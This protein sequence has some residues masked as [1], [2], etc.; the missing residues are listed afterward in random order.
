MSELRW[1]DSKP[2]LQSID[3]FDLRRIESGSL[4]ESLEGLRFAANRII[5]VAITPP[6]NVDYDSF[7]DSGDSVMMAFQA[8]VPSPSELSTPEAVEKHHPKSPY[9]R[10][11]LYPG[12]LNLIGKAITVWGRATTWRLVWE[13][14]KVRYGRL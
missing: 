1:P 10:A 11:I 7:R 4:L 13:Q 9:L 8:S 2:L 6:N 3:A 12:S 14:T 5:P